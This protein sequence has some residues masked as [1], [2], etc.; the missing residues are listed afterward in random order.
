MAAQGMPWENVRMV[1]VVGGLCVMPRRLITRRDRSLPAAVIATISNRP[2]V[3]N[4]KATA[5]RDPSVA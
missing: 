2:N 4:P 1:E 5:A 3:L